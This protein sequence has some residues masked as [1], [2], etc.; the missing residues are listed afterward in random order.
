MLVPKNIFAVGKVAAKE[1]ERY[2]INGVCLD[3]TPDGRPLAIATDGRRLIAA[4]WAE[5]K[6]E[7]L[8]EGLTL[9]DDVKG[10]TIVPLDAWKEIEK[11]V[12]KRAPRPSLK[13]AAV[14]LN[15]NSI[16]AVSTDMAS[17]KR[18]SAK[19]AA[20]I[21]PKWKQV[22]P[23]YDNPTCISFNPKYLA[24][25][26]EAVAEAAGVAEDCPTVTLAIQE[27]NRPGLIV[28]HGPNGTAVGVLMP[29]AADDKHD[30]QAKQVAFVR[31]CIADL[32]GGEIAKA[33]AEKPRKGKAKA[34]DADF[35]KFSGFVAERRPAGPW[36]RHG[37]CGVVEQAHA[38]MNGS[39]EHFR[40]WFAGTFLNRDHKEIVL[41]WT[42]CCEATEPQPCA[43]CE[44]VTAQTPTVEGQAEKSPAEATETRSAGFGAEP[45]EPE[46]A[47]YH[48]ELEA[49]R[50]KVLEIQAQ[51]AALNAQNDSLKSKVQQATRLK[52]LAERG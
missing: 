50:L 7:D 12:P 6:P 8:P 15:G 33:L 17:V 49:M 19:V 20:G 51:T 14:G 47:E 2:A 31:K 22:L 11:N 45:D 13:V 32:E 18:S 35:A 52:R 3:R 27:Y 5:G 4:T 26:A 23:R 36:H 46:T 43:S 42:P 41:G 10:E 1:Q 40:S 29:V 21:F 16:E 39:F 30:S 9:K 25:V 38:E 44:P 48:A 24:E 37:I 34:T 28:A